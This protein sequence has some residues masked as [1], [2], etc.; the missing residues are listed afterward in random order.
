MKKF[1]LLLLLLN[2]ATTGHASE[3]ITGSVVVEEN[4][5]KHR[6]YIVIYTN[7]GL[8]YAQVYSGSFDKDDVVI[9]EINSYGF[10]DVLVDGRSARLWIDDY[11]LT[12]EKA[13][14]KCLDI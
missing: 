7:N 5:C 13:I 3:M 1:I 11:W 9:G 2:K 10:K 12:K 14:A 8:V 6:D 4:T